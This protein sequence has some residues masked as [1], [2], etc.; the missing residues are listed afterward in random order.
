MAWEM[1]WQEEKIG[2]LCLDV[3]CK[4]IRMFPVETETGT[5][6]QKLSFLCLRII[7]KQKNT[8]LVLTLNTIRGYDFP[9]FT[10]KHAESEGKVLKESY[11]YQDE[12]EKRLI[13]LG[14]GTP[15]LKNKIMQ[16]FAE[17]FVGIA[18]KRKAA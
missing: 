13:Q 9:G 6:F 1:Q 7:I 5:E 14:G 4:R 17:R 12:F 16:C 18:T 11:P 8:V 3:L 15:E 10:I 2:K